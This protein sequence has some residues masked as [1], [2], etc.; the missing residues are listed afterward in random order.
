MRSVREQKAAAR[1]GAG[2]P[3]RAL[4]L[5]ARRAQ[6]YP[7]KVRGRFRSLKWAALL[8]LLGLYYVLPWVRWDRGPGAPDQAVLVDL[9]HER[10][11]FFFIE[12]WPQ[13]VYYLTGLLVLAAVGLF[14]ATSLAGRVWCGYAC[15]QTVWTDLFMW[16]ERQIEGDRSARIR[17]DKQPLSTGKIGRKTAKHAAWLAIAFLT[18]GAWIMYFVDAPTVVGDFFT[19]AAS[20]TVYFFVGLFTATTY[21]L[22]GMAREQV[23][24]YMCPWPRFQAAMLDEDSLVVTYNRHRGEPRGPIRKGE[25]R[26]ETGH[27]IDCK[28]CVAVCPTGIDIRDGLQLECI[29]C[30][31]CVDSCNEIMARVGLPPNLIAFD[32]E[33]RMAQ[34]AAKEKPAYRLI[35]PRTVLYFF[36]L[37][38]VAGLMVF[39]LATRDD[40]GVN[41][42]HDRTLFVRLSSGAIQ[43]SYDVKVLNKARTARRFD[44]TVEGLPGAKIVLVGRSTE[45]AARVAVSAPPDGLGEYRLHVRAPAAGITGEE[46]KIRFVV[47][48]EDGGTAVRETTFRGPKAQNR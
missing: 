25:K 24:T 2:A 28:Q 9:N 10:G 33:R 23:C 27:C 17:L 15:P 38:G 42:L 16:V 6:V 4:N 29:G 11:Y 5:Y 3:P 39:A 48:G 35:R 20:E 37:L 47:T 45:P 41:V 1:G 21:L 18:G 26:D 30:G 8:G 31:L 14:L 13:E 36:I 34:R 12:I 44:L 22:A 43:N 46:T 40:Q 32:T 19:G 7:R